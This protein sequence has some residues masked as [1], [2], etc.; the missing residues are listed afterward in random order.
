MRKILLLL[1]LILCIPALAQDT[2][3]Y[4][5]MTINLTNMW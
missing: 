1:Y 5:G 4:K 2:A 3:R